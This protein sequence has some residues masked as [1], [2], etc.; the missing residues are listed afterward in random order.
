MK[1]SEHVESALHV[2]V[3]LAA[4]SGSGGLPV[5]RLAEFHDLPL[6]SLSKQLQLLSA[7]GLVVGSAG[8]VG[9]YRLS[10]T[11]S[12]ISVL[13]V[14]EAVDG[15]DRGFRCREIRREGTCTG[16]NRKYSPRC[17]IAST[18]D[19]AED[20]W[21]ASLRKV[22]LAQIGKRITSQLDDR[23]RKQTTAWLDDNERKI[24]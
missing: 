7:A 10:R 8:R 4:G 12:E 17:A 2:C 24:R 19:A 18:M 5:K 11:P 15:T 1:I 9:G 14:V 6:A 13:E 21:R 20:A 22:S 23:T 16:P 3:I